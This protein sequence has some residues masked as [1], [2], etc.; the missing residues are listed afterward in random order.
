MMLRDEWKL[1]SLEPVEQAS[2]FRATTAVV[3][4]RWLVIALLAGSRGGAVYIDDG[5][6]AANLWFWLSF[7]AS[8]TFAVN[9]ITQLS[10]NRRMKKC[11]KLDPAP[12]IRVLRNYG[13]EELGG[14]FLYLPAPQRAEDQEAR[15]WLRI[16]KAKQAVVGGPWRIE[17]ER[18]PPWLPKTHPQICSNEVVFYEVYRLRRDPLAI[19]L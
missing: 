8:A 12:L 3:P 19:F 6:A 1:A 17:A 13:V 18:V 15:S 4:W 9:W 7:A 16:L 10:Q 14:L 5:F 2:T 11:S